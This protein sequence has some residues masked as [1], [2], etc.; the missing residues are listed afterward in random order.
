MSFQPI[1]EISNKVEISQCFANF[2]EITLCKLWVFFKTLLHQ[3][4]LPTS[5]E[6]VDRSSL[7]VYFSHL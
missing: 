1:W 6:I 2:T 5:S 4:L 3:S 7:K